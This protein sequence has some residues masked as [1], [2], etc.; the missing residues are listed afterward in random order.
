MSGQTWCDRLLVFGVVLTER[1]DVAVDHDY[2]DYS[3]LVLTVT[4]SEL[5]RPP[6]HFLFVWKFSL[7]EEKRQVQKLVYFHDKYKVSIQM[8][9]IWRTAP[10]F[11][12][13][14]LFC[15]LHL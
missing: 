12:A 6:S 10:S 15:K 3:K 9:L 2:S 8:A 1:L 14:V 13:N 5:Q 7:A 4:V 11:S